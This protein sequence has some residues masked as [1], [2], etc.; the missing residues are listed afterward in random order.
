MIPADTISEVRGATDIVKIVS[1]HVELK[2][3]GQNHFGLCPFH[4]EKSPSF[5]VHAGKQIY[6][7]FGC[8]ETG[9]VFSFLMRVEGRPF[10]EVLRDLAEISGIALPEQTRSPEALARER[11]RRSER[12][13]LFELNDRV[14]RYFRER[15][16]GAEG[17]GARAYLRGRGVPADGATAESFR[18]GFAP[19]GWDNLLR[20]LTAEKVSLPLAERLGLIVPK[21]ARHYDRFR[22]RVIF[23]LLGPAGEVIGFGGRILESD[24]S[25]EAA[26][27]INTP[28]TP[29]YRKGESLYGLHAARKALA[30]EGGVAIVVEGNFDVLMLHEAGFATAV[31][32]MGTALTEKQALLLKR[33]AKQAVAA[34]DGDG[35]GRAA[36]RKCVATFLEAD[37]DAKVAIVPD[38]EDPDTLVRTKGADALRRCIKIAR[39]TVDYLL[40]EVLGAAERTI[41]ARVS[42]LEEVAPVLARIANPTVQDLYLGKVVEMLQIDASRVR[43]AVKAAGPP[44]R[45]D[46]P[47][48]R[49]LASPAP[50]DAR[51]GAAPAEAGAR[52]PADVMKLLAL[53]VDRP[54][55][56]PRLR[57]DG[58]LGLVA[59]DGLRQ[60]LARFCDM[61]AAGAIDHAALLA[62][63]PEAIRGEVEREIFAGSFEKCEDPARA[64]MDI[65]GK[66]RAERIVGE[67]E[68]LRRQAR[69][70]QELGAEEEVREIM[71]RV[72]DLEKERRTLGVHAER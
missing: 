30:R 15:L 21:D 3:K 55:L 69:R 26:K 67:A 25:G 58:A 37:L 13:R 57:A 35:A 31:A 45:Q 12:E 40:D 51:S 1:A 29:V 24:G 65:V 17:S 28:E 56:A 10:F 72:F 33:F 52:V 14:A 9:D 49:A 53:V 63:A 34:F 54:E 23:P 27:Y 16:L 62:A 60:V 70:A 11:E 47:V 68:G 66:L 5:S 6:H 2:R 7:C 19:V 42:A 43:A 20:F 22:G 59:H 71:S 41:P 64:L 8:G 39:P 32:P 38:G 61:Q 44:S 4:S 36:S 18:V 48:R 46:E 50:R